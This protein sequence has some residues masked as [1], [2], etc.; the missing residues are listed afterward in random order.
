MLVLFDLD[1]TL[2]ETTQSIVEPRLDRVLDKMIS[3]GLNIEDRDEALLVLER[4][5]R[6]GSS[7]K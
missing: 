7:S 4:L 2:I 1:D 6:T 3:S 5:N